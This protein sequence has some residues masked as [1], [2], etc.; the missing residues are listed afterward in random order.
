MS[1]ITFWSVFFNNFILF[2]YDPPTPLIFL[3]GMDEKKYAK[4]QNL[5]E[6]LKPFTFIFFKLK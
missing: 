3:G 2:L 5:R 1:L 4:L 6:L